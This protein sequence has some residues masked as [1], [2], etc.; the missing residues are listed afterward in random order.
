MTLLESLIKGAIEIIH[1]TLG[2]GGGVDN[3]S[4]QDL[5]LFKTLVLRLLEVK[6]PVIW[7]MFQ[8]KVRLQ[9]TLSF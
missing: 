5:Y 3:V 2:G 6:I 8:S 1:D 4:R 7:H 9:K